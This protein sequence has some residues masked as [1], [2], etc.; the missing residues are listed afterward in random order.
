MADR[1]SFTRWCYFIMVLQWMCCGSSATTTTT[2][3]TCSGL[4]NSAFVFVKPSANTPQ[5][6]ELVRNT[7][8]QHGCSINLERSIN[9]ATIDRHK[10]IDQHYYAIASKATI[11]T[12][13][14]IPVPREKFQQHFKEDW[15]VVLKE[16][17]TCNAME[18][19]KRFSCTPTEL[20]EAWRQSD[21][22]KLGGGFY[23]GL[24]KMNG[25][26]LYVFNAFFM[27]MRSKFV[28][29]S[30]SIHCFEIE[31]DPN[32]LSWADFRGKV[33]GPTDP[34]AA[35]EGSLRKIILDTYEDL[36]IKEKPNKG[37]NGVH[38]SASPFEG[39]AEKMNWLKV[40]IRKD[41]FGSA[42]I[43]EGISEK[44]LKEWSLDPQVQLE[45]GT[46]GSIFDALEDMDAA[47]CLAKLK[48]LSTLVAK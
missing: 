37:D 17:R 8:K 1:S 7:L 42:L 36:G 26:S 43:A 28:E 48:G 2:E 27:Q 38:A 16:D 45:D 6:V 3:E 25:Q 31:W 46:L 5:T 22:V 23:C 47:A 9:G 4:K 20:D 13:K 14:E 10:L 35:P 12:P 24:V 11:L 39:L 29:K 34:T 32:Q 18:A 15:D 40:P 33:L 41:T 30:A 21:V 44:L 19:C